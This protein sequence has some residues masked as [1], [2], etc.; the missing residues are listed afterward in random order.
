MVTK[1]KVKCTI[2][3]ALRLCTGRTAHKGSRCI[4]LLF[5]DH[6]TRR[7]WG[8]SVT[9]RERPG[10]HCTGD[11]VGLQGWSG[12]MRKTSSP[13]GF[14]PRTVHPVA[15]LYTDWAIRPAEWTNV[16]IIKELYFDVLIVAT[17]RPPQKKKHLQLCSVNFKL[18]SR[19]IWKYMRCTAD[20]PWAD[21][22]RQTV[23]TD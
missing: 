13:S 20:C 23:A 12:Q 7:G 15:S 18:S 17:D 8:V 3:Q 22:M 11:W 21:Y 6:G 16:A 10:T 5:L 9:P 19:Y 1:I 14:D 4:A 2:V